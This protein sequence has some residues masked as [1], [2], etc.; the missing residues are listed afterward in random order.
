LVLGTLVVTLPL[1]L[2]GAAGAK[3]HVPFPVVARSSFGFYFS[4]FVVVT[5]KRILPNIELD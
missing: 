1:V 2:N 4:R 3:L 5:R